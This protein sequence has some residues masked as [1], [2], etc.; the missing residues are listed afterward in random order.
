[1]ILAV[2]IKHPH[3]VKGAKGIFLCLDHR[4]RKDQFFLSALFNL[5]L[6]TINLAI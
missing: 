2:L 5:L 1:M 3:S 4:P 6:A